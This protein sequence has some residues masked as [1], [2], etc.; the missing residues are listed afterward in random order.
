LRIKEV[1]N[2]TYY[3]GNEYAGPMD[4]E[5]QY[6]V[7]ASQF[8]ELSPSAIGIST[9]P[10]REQL[11]SLKARIFQGASKVELGFLGVGKGS[12]AQGATTP[13][14]YG[15][16]EREAIRELAKINKI[17]LS[18]HA[19]PAAQGFSGFDPERGAFSDEARQR[20]IFEIQRAI[21]FAADTAGGG[22]VVAHLGEWHRP[23]FKAVEKHGG[24]FEAYPEEKKHAAIYVA[25]DETGQIIPLRTDTEV[26]E[27]V[28][29]EIKKDPKT[30]EEIEIYDYNEDG[31][32][33]LQKFNFDQIVE[34]E[35]KKDPTLSP[36]KAFLKHFFDVQKRRARAEELRYALYAEQ[37]Q[38]EFEEIKKQKD[39]N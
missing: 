32:V 28:V 39:G 35:R 17:E 25:D 22:P 26:F 7:E 18:T 6:N 27:P 29:K 24:R 11:E 1:I 36:E 19:A 37:R 31:T 10:M 12:M 30:G 8:G 4:I 14:M 33:K 21:D 20:N 23:I 38:K 15:R 3:F 34:M 5:R 16:E 9:P 2:M 13:E